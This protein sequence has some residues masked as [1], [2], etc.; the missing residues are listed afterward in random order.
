MKLKEVDLSEALSDL[1]KYGSWSGLGD[2]HDRYSRRVEKGLMGVART[3][4]PTLALS[5]LTDGTARLSHQPEAS[6]TITFRRG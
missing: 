1:R 4:D 3:A 5:G 6:K 2:I